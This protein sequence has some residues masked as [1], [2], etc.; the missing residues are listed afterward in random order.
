MKIG[1]KEYGFRLTVG[2]SIQ[3]SKLCPDGDLSRIAEA[4]SGGYG[5]QADVM[6]RLIVALSNGYAAAEEFE[7]RT[8]NRLS[9]EDVLSL[10]PA[11]FT[12][13]SAEAFRV[14]GVD[15]KG[16]IEVESEK[17]AAAEG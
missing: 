2:A 5:K 11:V 14:F 6:A 10:S 17:K 12:E 4:V 3:I 8:A 7:G 9:Y 15:V 13:V 1:T 16:D